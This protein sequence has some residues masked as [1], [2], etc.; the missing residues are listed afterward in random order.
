MR[1]GGRQTIH[2]PA[3]R[4]D[5]TTEFIKFPGGEHGGSWGARIKGTPRHDASPT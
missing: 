2:D 1:S 3:N 5:I 4:I